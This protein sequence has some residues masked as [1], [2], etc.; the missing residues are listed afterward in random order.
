MLFTRRAPVTLAAALLVSTLLVPA[1][2]P[3]ADELDLEALSRLRAE[4]TDRSQVMEIAGY[5]T[6]VYGPRLA[7]SP[8]I[9]KAADWTMGRMREWGLS[10]VHLESFPFGRGW[11]NRRFVAMMTAPQPTPLQRRRV[12]LQPRS[13]RRRA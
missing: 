7:G 8:M 10:A 3:L 13:R 2:R 9:R 1:A 6:D 11:E 12:R 4:G 5:L